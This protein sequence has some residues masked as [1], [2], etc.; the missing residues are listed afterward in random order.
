MK[1]VTHETEEGDMLF[2][3]AYEAMEEFGKAQKDQDR[4]QDE[5]QGVHQ[6]LGPSRSC[7]RKLERRLQGG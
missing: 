6:L 4:L 1:K 5:L 3:V 2:A 7:E